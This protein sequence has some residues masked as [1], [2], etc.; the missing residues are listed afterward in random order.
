M[1]PYNNTSQKT[2]LKNPYP[3]FLKFTINSIIY[4]ASFKLSYL[5]SLCSLL[6]PSISNDLKRVIRY[7]K[8]SKPKNKT[9]NASNNRLLTCLLGEVDRRWWQFLRNLL[10]FT[11]N[12][13]ML[14]GFSV[15][16]TSTPWSASLFTMATPHATSK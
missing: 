16:W 1:A 3:F 15:D 12:S 6:S 14:T 11:L 9:L 5:R 10:A 13:G 2:A 8:I 7:K 4:N